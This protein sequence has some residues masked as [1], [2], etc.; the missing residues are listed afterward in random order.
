MI[1]LLQFLLGSRKGILQRSRK[2][3]FTENR[4][5]LYPGT[6]SFQR[7][8]TFSPKIYPLKFYCPTPF[9][10]ENNFNLIKSLPRDF[11]IILISNL[12][13]SF[14]I[15]LVAVNFSLLMQCTSSRVKSK[16]VPRFS[17]K[18]RLCTLRTKYVNRSQVKSTILSYRGAT[19]IGICK[20]V[21]HYAPKKPKIC[22]SRSQFQRPQTF[23][24]GSNECMEELDK[25]CFLKS[26]TLMF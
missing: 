19:L 2:W 17:Q 13:N 9:S 22:L 21:V 3:T 23:N 5:L 14:D 6:V 24:Q 1:L 12:V 10:Q 18:L 25:S 15:R 7:G 11:I 4:A 8:C 16:K 20:V 26:P